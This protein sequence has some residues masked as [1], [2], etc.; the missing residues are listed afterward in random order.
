[1]T[2]EP[3]L[4]TRAQRAFILTIT[5]QAIVVLVM[6]SITFGM[7]RGEVNISNPRYRTLSCYLAL[8]ALAEYIVYTYHETD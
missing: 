4:A 2:V 7:V 5:V 3:L 1:M 6:V 8:F